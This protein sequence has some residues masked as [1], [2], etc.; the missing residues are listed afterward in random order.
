MAL[1]AE[2]F[3]DVVMPPDD[4]GQVRDLDGMLHRTNSAT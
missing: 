1:R 4:L 3:D 2:A